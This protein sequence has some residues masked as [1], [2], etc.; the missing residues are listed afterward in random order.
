MRVAVAS[1]NPVKIEAAERAF[2]LV[3]PDTDFEF[4]GFS[5]ESGVPD[6]PVGDEETLKGARNRLENLKKQVPEADYFVA[7]EGGLIPDGDSFY[8]TAWFIAENKEGVQGKARAATFDVPPAISKLIHE[9]MELGTASDHV[10][11]EKDSK[12]KEGT[13]G[14]LTGNVI[15]RTSY[16]THPMVCCLIPLA[17]PD[18]YTS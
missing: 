16:Y 12:R 9:G 17:N 15:T 2:A 4:A 14:L 6:Q 3:F 8:A 1:E 18:L 7:M 5:I 13:I 11:D 10:F